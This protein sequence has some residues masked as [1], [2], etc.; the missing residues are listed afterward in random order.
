MDRGESGDEGE[1]LIMDRR[2][3]D[4]TI[5]PHA[6]FCMFSKQDALVVERAE[7]QQ[8]RHQVQRCQYQHG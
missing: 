8:Q 6:S 7:H 3:L 5:L 4:I 2:R 1:W